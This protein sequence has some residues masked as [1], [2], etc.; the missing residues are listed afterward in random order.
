MVAVVHPT[1]GV[2]RS[3]VDV[4]QGSAATLALKGIMASLE[5]DPVT[6]SFYYE[7]VTKP[8]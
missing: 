8:D 5:A 1:E 3:S 2:L 4:P 6:Q 7:D